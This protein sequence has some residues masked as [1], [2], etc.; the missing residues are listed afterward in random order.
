MNYKIKKIFFIKLSYSD[1]KLIFIFLYIIHK[2]TTKMEN[3]KHINTLIVKYLTKKIKED[4]V[5]V[6]DIDCKLG[7]GADLIQRF[8]DICDDEFFNQ[9]DE[10]VEISDECFNDLTK[11]LKFTDFCYMIEQ[12]N[13]YYQYNSF[14]DNFNFDNPEWVFNTYCYVFS[15]YIFSMDDYDDGDVSD[16]HDFRFG[17]PEYNEFYNI[18]EKYKNL[19]LSEHYKMKYNKLH[20]LYNNYTKLINKKKTIKK[21]FDSSDFPEDVIEKVITY[22]Y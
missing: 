15:R 9:E 12:I 20:K 2:R 10:I 21:I 11:P 16:N 18:V 22:S 3:L 13:I 19:Y 14:I 6:I 8:M 1:L 4:M 17:D 5:Y 7:N